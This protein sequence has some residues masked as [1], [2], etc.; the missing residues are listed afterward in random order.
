MVQLKILSGKQAGTSWVA[1]HFPVRIGRGPTAEF[2]ADEDGVW[3]EHLA[4]GFS[5]ADGFTFQAC[6]EAVVCLNGELV[7]AGSLRN[8]DLMEL[9]ALK[10]QFWLGEPRQRGLTAREILIWVGIAAVSLAQIALIY[11]LPK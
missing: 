6:S 11:W 3:D 4:I 10:L 9:G 2:Q 8:G 1:R 5:S 7:R